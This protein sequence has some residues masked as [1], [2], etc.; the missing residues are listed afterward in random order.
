MVRDW[1]R[2]M[3]NGVVRSIGF[4]VVRS[5]GVGG[6]GVAVWGRGRGVGSRCIRG[7]VVGSGVMG[8]MV[9]CGVWV[10]GLSISL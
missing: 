6:W 3:R 9:R 8:D 2:V 7:R 10:G 1:S 4:R 5:R